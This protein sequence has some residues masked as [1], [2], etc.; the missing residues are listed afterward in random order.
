MYLDNFNEIRSTL[1]E[2]KINWLTSQVPKKQIKQNLTKVLKS[3]IRLDIRKN[4]FSE[5]IVM[6]WKML[7][8][9]VMESSPLKVFKKR[10]DAVLKD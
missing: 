4:F 9:E 6:H 8:R 5:S 3:T 7:P 2:F 10:V 1:L